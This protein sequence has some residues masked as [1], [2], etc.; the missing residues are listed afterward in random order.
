M[1]SKRQQI[2]LAI[3]LERKRQDDKWGGPEHDDQHQIDFWVQLIQD[4]AGWARVMAGM[5]NRQKTRTR[6]LQVAALAVAALEKMDREDGWVDE[7]PT[8][9][10]NRTLE[11]ITK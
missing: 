7:E 10:G 1:N 2:L 9:R 6:L 8:N 3:D 4:Y 5:G 11:V